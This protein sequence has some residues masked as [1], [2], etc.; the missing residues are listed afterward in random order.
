MVTSKYESAVSVD[1]L[2]CRR[3][4]IDLLFGVVIIGGDRN[5]SE[6]YSWTFSPACNGPCES[7][8]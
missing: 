7:P 2:I 3:T 8:A 4:V 5:Q 6:A 1:M